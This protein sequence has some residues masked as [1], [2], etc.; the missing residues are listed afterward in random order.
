MHE[1]NVDTLGQAIAQR[2][3]V[4][5]TKKWSLSPLKYFHT[6]QEP[7]VFTW[8][9]VVQAAGDANAGL[10]LAN[11]ARWMRPPDDEEL[12][13]RRPHIVD[14]DDVEWLAKSRA[15][16]VMET[17]L[18]ES[19]I[20]TALKKLQA[21]QLIERSGRTELLRTTHTF[22]SAG[23]RGTKVLARMVHM[24][25]GAAKGILLSQMHYWFSPGRNQRARVTQQYRGEWWWA[26]RYEDIAGQ[27]GLSVREARSAVNALVQSNLVI[28]DVRRFLGRNTL[29]LRFNIGAFQSAWREHFATWMEMQ[30]DQRLQGHVEL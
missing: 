2:E 14:I 7:W 19:Q 23:R 24:T 21:A 16:F 30:A 10:L 20:K 12:L 18:T 11:I 15:A 22:Q 29:H 3:R 9:E 28:K 25:G 26:A 27:T 13:P 4:E 17:G 8:P 1:V 6:Q 5:S